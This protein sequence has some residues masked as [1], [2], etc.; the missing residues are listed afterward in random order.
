MCNWIALKQ[1]SFREKIVQKIVLHETWDRFPAFSAFT[2]QNQIQISHVNL[3][4]PL[5]VLS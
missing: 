2:M 5:C 1:I 3:K 4:V